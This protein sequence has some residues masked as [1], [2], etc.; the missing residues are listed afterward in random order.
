VSEADRR[1]ASADAKTACPLCTTF[2]P[3]NLLRWLSWAA[4]GLLGAFLAALLSACTPLPVSHP[5]LWSPGNG[6]TDYPGASRDAGV[7]DGG[8]RNE[9]KPL[10]WLDGVAIGGEH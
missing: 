5:E 6:A 8:A 3:C 9:G 10:V 4:A 7:I 1:Q 2:G